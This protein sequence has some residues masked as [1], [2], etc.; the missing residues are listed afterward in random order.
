MTVRKRMAII[1]SYFKGESY[2]LLGP[3]MAA[4]IIEQNTDYDCIVIAVTS[5]D[6]K[7]LIKKFFSDYSGNENAL[8]DLKRQLLS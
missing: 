7:S 8:V 5:D 4:T 2:G 1:S 3:Q 6:D